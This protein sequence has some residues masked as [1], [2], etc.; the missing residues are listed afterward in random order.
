M[1]IENKSF[2]DLVIDYFSGNISETDQNL[3]SGLL[4][5]DEE[6][7]IR[8]EEMLKL[9]AISFVPSLEVEKQRNFERLME[10]IKSSQLPNG[11]HHWAHR[12]IRIAAIFILAVS[13]FATSFY[14]YKRTAPSNGMLSY[15]ETIVPI[16][17]QTKIILPDSSIVWLNSG[18]SLKYSQSF[19][20]KDRE[21]YLKGEGYFEVSKDK[22]KPFLVHTGTLDIKVVGTVFNVSC[23]NE[24]AD[25]V[26]D[27]IEGA[28]NVSIPSMKNSD[29]HM[30]KPDEEI[31]YNKKTKQLKL[32]QIEAYKSAL[33]TTGKLCFVDATIEDIAR[34]LERKFN[35]K[36]QIVDDRIKNEHFSGSLN[37]NLSINEILSY[38]DVDNKFV[39]HQV[40]NTIR[41]DI[42]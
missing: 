4:E 30:M 20:R 3:L 39:I 35:V 12:F 37:L 38:L 10:Q 25:V 17:S 29:S 42:K 32:S 11:S 9:R 14:I 19:F 41:V 6:F 15:F 16:G 31:S 26:V 13:V 23:Y 33:W 24:D 2:D 28:V 34:D 21:V 36:I 5:S 27:L 18:T 40:G 8:F 7:R 22:K 1:Q